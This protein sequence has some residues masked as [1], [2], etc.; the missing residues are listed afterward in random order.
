[1]DERPD[2]SARADDRELA[3]AEQL[4]LAAWWIDGYPGAGAIEPA[5]AQH[6]PIGPVDAGDRRL[7]VAERREPSTHLRRGRVVERS[8]LALD[9]ATGA[10]VQP[11]V[12]LDDKALDT[13]RVARRQQMVGALGA[14]PVG[15]LELAIEAS[16][17]DHRR[18]G[19][20]LVHDHV[21]L[22]FADGPAHGV[23]IQGVGHDGLGSDAEQLVAFGFRAGHPNDIVPI[24]D[25][26]RNKL[27]AER[28]RGA[29]D[30]HFHGDSFP[31]GH[32]RR[33]NGASACDSSGRPLALMRALVEVQPS[34]ALKAEWRSDTRFAR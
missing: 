5:V 7:E 12:A 29:G 9:R 16:H 26:H 33:R 1:V 28:S 3:L 22:R 13:C 23:G 11:D 2:T 31:V 8:V 17:V 20:E 14:K 6:H 10:G 24:G 15:E 30:E 34:C 19:G 25:Q 32:L 21:W 4:D 18:D 27:L